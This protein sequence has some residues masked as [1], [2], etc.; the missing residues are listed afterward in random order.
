VESKGGDVKG[1]DVLGV[2]VMNLIRTSPMKPAIRRDIV[3]VTAPALC[4]VVVFVRN[5]ECTMAI[6]NHS[7]ERTNVLFREVHPRAVWNSSFLRYAL[8]A[9]KAGPLVIHLALGVI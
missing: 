5:F 9:A 3:Y 7:A 2:S 4:P 6:P 8:L 1:G